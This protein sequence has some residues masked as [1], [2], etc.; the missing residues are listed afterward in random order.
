M[1]YSER[2][3]S[4]RTQKKQVLM[5]NNYDGLCDCEWPECESVTKCIEFKIT[6]RPTNVNAA[7]I[8]NG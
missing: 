4:Q 7:N 3:Q 5:T 6:N 2:T 1:A 8:S